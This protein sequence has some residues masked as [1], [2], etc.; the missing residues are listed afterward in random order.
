MEIRKAANIKEVEKCV[1]LYYNY[2]DNALMPADYDKSLRNL[3]SVWRQGS[4]FRVIVS[5]NEVVGW[6]YCVLTD[7]S[8]VKYPVFQQAFYFS[9]LSGF[10]AA[11]ALLLAHESMVK[12]AEE[13]EYKICVSAASHE[14]TRRVLCKLLKKAGWTVKGHLAVFH[15]KHFKKLP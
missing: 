2:N 13:K 7:M 5:N 10:K 12:E 1:E 8:F 4:F 15:T 9:S 6:I 11:R 3:V 14:D